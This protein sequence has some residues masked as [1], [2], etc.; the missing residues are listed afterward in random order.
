MAEKVTKLALASR[1]IVLILQLLANKLLPDHQT[2]VFRAPFNPANKVTWLDK[3][4][5][6]CLNGFRH[7]DAEYFLHIAEHGYTYENTLAFYP[8]YPMVV[9][10]GAHL[11]HT[12]L[13]DFM[14]MRSCCLLVGVV[15]NVALFC[16]AANILYALT[17]RIFNDLN[18][19]WN[20][21]LLFCFNPASIFFTAA[22]SETLFCLLSL[23]VMLECSTQIRAVR[24][25][26]ALA[27]NIAARSNGLVNM[28]FPFYFIVR[29]FILKRSSL[30]SSLL[31]MAL[32]LLFSLIPLTFFN[33]Y[34]FQ[35]FCVSDKATNHTEAILNYGRQKNYVLSGYRYAEQSPW[36]DERFPFPYSYIQSHYW[37]VG[38]LRYYELK[39]IPNFMLA[40]PILIFLFWHCVKYLRDFQKNLLPKYPLLHLLKEYKTL[41]F[42]LHALALTVFCIFFVHI[43]IST[44]LLCSA[45]P[46]VYWFASDHMPKS[47]DKLQLRSKA[48]LIFLWFASYVLVG[49]TM[50]S[51]NLPWT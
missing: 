38:F 48:G 22:Y 19:S 47:L 49:T 17:Q 24:S 15:L 1:I 27:L 51:N 7:W 41:P 34:A 33:F 28:G 10:S 29:K 14:N 6:F 5:N 9:K 46:C 3:T 12:M 50:F 16:K 18:K 20:V 4:I 39:Q 31:K 32:C 37:K 40:L 13:A 43:Q 35:L 2:D 45:T 42:I 8:L 21:A 11:L 44:R 23:Y 30:L 25:T 26:F 36:C